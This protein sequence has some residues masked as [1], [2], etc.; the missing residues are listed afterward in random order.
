PLT[1]TLYLRFI[2]IN[3]PAETTVLPGRKLIINWSYEFEIVENVVA[4]YL[5]LL[6]P[7]RPYM[8]SSSYA[9]T[10]F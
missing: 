3:D 6:S 2:F 9:S 4:I 1:D 8:D 5:S 7:E 10:P